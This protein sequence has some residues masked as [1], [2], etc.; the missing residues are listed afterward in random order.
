MGQLA[1]TEAPLPP[2]PASICS[3]AMAA[4]M[5]RR[6]LPTRRRSGSE[7]NERGGLPAARLRSCC[8]AYTPS[9]R[10]ITGASV[11]HQSSVNLPATNF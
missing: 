2:A 3:L 9:R 1:P 6:H 10:A 7:K 4:A 5:R 8:I 11:A